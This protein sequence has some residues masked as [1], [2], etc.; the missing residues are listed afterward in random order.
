M[1]SVVCTN[2]NK[3]MRGTS[4][5]SKSGEKHIYY[6]CYNCKTTIAEKKL[7]KPLIRF[8][9]DMVDYFLLVDNTFKPYLNQDTEQE[10]ERYNKFVERAKS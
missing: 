4:C 3:V 8:L 1:Q 9:N 6:Q 7:E 2:C 10:V 5:A